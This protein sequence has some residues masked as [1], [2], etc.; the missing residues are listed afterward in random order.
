MRFGRDIIV[1]RSHVT[2]QFG[3]DWFRRA[4]GEGYTVH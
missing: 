2:N 4:I 3:I 1:Q